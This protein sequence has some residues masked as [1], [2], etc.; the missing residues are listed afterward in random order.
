[1]EQ[2]FIGYDK[3]FYDAIPYV[4]VE[5]GPDEDPYPQRWAIEPSFVEIA[6]KLLFQKNNAKVYE[7]Y[8]LPD[9]T[10]IRGFILRYPEFLFYAPEMKKLFDLIK[11]VRIIVGLLQKPYFV[12]HVRGLHDFEGTFAF[13][14]LF[15][16]VCGLEALAE[17]M[18]SDQSFII[19]AGKSYCAMSA[20]AKRRAADLLKKPDTRNALRQIA[21][22]FIYSNAALGLNRHENDRVIGIHTIERIASSREVKNE[23]SWL[24]AFFDD[25][26]SQFYS[27][28]NDLDMPVAILM[29]ENDEL[30]NIVTVGDVSLTENGLLAAILNWLLDVGYS[31]GKD[32]LKEEG[33]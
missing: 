20:D 9:D 30:E 2:L 31:M 18:A 12:K 23:Y 8:D 4:K 14:E 32:T 15:H 1:M 25:Q 26:N 27:V 17:E 6:S 16:E 19:E 3:D 29:I 7:E 5:P 24:Y 10:D 22:G 11:D 33:E 13:L 28:R 21:W